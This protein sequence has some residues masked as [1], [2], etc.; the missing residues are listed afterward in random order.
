M[1]GTAGNYAIA[2]GRIGS[3]K[4][5]DTSRAGLRQLALSAAKPATIQANLPFRV[6]HLSCSRQFHTLVQEE[7]PI[8]ERGFPRRADSINPRAGLS[9]APNAF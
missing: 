9:A 3:R 4:P 6:R 2:E 5:D 7:I 1:A 8:A